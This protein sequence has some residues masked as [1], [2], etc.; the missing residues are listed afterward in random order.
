MRRLNFDQI[1]GHAWPWG[2]R[3]DWLRKLRL[4]RFFAFSCPL[5]VNRLKTLA[6]YLSLLFDLHKREKMSEIP[7]L[8]LSSN[9]AENH[10]CLCALDPSDY[11]FMAVVNKWRDEVWTE[12]SS[13]A[14]S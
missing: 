4:F 3:N 14:A 10:G 8:N 7:M 11:R 5:A 9:L 2:Q 6:E 1:F 13:L 12:C